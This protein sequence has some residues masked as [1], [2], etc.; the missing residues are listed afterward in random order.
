MSIVGPSRFVFEFATEN[1]V[2]EYVSTG[3][4]LLVR[5]LTA[6]I[7]VMTLRQIF[8]MSAWWLEKWRRFIV[9][10]IIIVVSL[11]WFKLNQYIDTL[12]IGLLWMKNMPQDLVLNPLGEVLTWG[13]ESWKE[14]STFDNFAHPIPIG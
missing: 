5:S 2:T 6:L 8:Y 10:L 13:A 7:T 12:L 14:F 1:I 9:L 11:M 3:L 4:G